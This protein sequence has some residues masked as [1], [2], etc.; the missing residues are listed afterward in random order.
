MSEV[1]IAL[2]GKMRAGKSLATGYLTLH[3]GFQPFAFGDELKDAFHRAFPHI[4][5][6]PKPR[7]Y[8]Q[9]FGQWARKTIDEDIWVN[10]CMREVNEYI[11][12]HSCPCGKSTVLVLVEDCRQPNEYERLKREGFVIVRIS[13]SDNLRL[14]RARR[15]G[16]VFADEDLAHETE[17]YIDEFAVDYEVT[18][19]GSIIELEAQLDNI[20]LDLGVKGG[21]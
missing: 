2:T 10:A 17:Q 14:A 3:Y 5:R 6:Y 13:A 15:E 9:S 20:M 7:V 4:A 12:R 19:N 16:D 18:N 1:K 21:V 11:D 8:Y